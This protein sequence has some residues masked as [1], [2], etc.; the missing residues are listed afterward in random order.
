METFRMRLIISIVQIA[1]IT[2]SNCREEEVDV[3]LLSSV[4]FNASVQSVIQGGEATVIVL[5]DKAA[6]IDCSVRVSITGGNAVYGY[7]YTTD[8]EIINGSF[9]IA[10][11]KGQTSAQFKVM[12]IDNTLS[13]TASSSPF[14]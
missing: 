9:A 3:V 2:L 1:L 5:L 13:K 4:Q 7:S 6:D 11:A 12:T 8:L 10:I 14:A